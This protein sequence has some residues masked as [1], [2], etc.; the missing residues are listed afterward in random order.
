MI[1]ARLWVLSMQRSAHGRK[2]L[3]PHGARILDHHVHP[4]VRARSADCP[5][6]HRE[7]KEVHRSLT[8]Q[9]Y[10]SAPQADYREVLAGRS[11]SNQHQRAAREPRTELLECAAFLT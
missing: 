8:A 1:C 3:L 2:M 5:S 7:D 10:P 4:K 9:P 11:S 6:H